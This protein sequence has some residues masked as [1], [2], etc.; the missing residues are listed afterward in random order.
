[1][2]NIPAGTYEVGADLADGFHVASQERTV[3]QFWIDV[4]QVT[5]EQYA[6]YL[7]QSGQPP[8]LTWPGQANHPVKGVTWEQAAAYCTWANKRLP[9]ELEWEIAARGPGADP[10]LYPWGD[11]PLA[12]GQ[13]NDLPRS[14]TYE[15]GSVPFN[16]SPFGIFDMSGNV[17]EWVGEPYDLVPA[18]EY[19]LRGGRHGFLKDSAYRQTAAPDDPRFTPLAGFRCA[20]DQVEGA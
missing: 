3:V 5:N 2:A 20:A 15:A 4:R 14:E 7:D 8:P 1:M 18:G 19:I 6:Q 10:P 13:V 11:D 9:T 12:D 16:Q 17:W